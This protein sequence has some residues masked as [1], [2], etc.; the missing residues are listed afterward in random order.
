[1]LIPGYTSEDLTFIVLR[2][3][4]KI[5]IL[6]LCLFPVISISGHGT[7]TLSFGVPQELLIYR[8]SQT[9]YNGKLW[10]RKHSNVHGNEFFT[11]ALWNRGDV[12]INDR[13][14]RN[15]DLRYDI[16]NDDLLIRRSDGVVIILNREKI[17]GFS[18]SIGEEEYRFGN[19]SG[20]DITGFNGYANILYDGRTALLLKP[21][22]E[23]LPL[24]YQ[25]IY[26]LFVQTDYLYIKKN[27][28]ITRIRS[29]KGLLDLLGDRGKE[30]R[31]FIR[32]NR[33][34]VFPKQPWTL[35]PVLRYYDSLSD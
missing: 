30:I 28:T 3:D 22:K 7:D 19:F 34:D 17:F 32:I 5:I 8:D 25:K 21:V 9:L 23:I 26:D 24:G 27:G 10:Y 16:L 11:S 20:K 33:L 18:I 13:I 1:M 4:K 15:N 14:Y 6:F 12:I 31:N 35:I 2:Q 29:R